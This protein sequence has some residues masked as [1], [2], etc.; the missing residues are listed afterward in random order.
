MIFVT[1][2]INIV[3]INLI[4]L[5]L[6]IIIYEIT[7]MYYINSNEYI[8]EMILHTVQCFKSVKCKQKCLKMKNTRTIQINYSATDYPHPFPNNYYF[9]HYSVCSKDT[10]IFMYIVTECK[11]Y[12]ERMAVRLTWGKK[13]T[14]ATLKFIIGI[15]DNICKKTYNN[16]NRKYKDLLQI[17]IYESFANE[18]LFSLYA[19]KYLNVLCPYSHYFIKLDVD[20]FIDFKSIINLI[21]PFENLSYQ[22]WGAEKQKWKRVNDNQKF[23][24]SSPISVANFYNSLFP[25]NGIDV[26][27]GFITIFSSDLPNILFNFSL[28]YPMLMRIDD[29]YISWLLYKLNIKI[30]R[31]S[32]Y[33]ILPNRCE[34]FKNVTV[35]HRI[36]SIDMI[37]YSLFYRHMQ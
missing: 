35:I 17:N 13:I 7:T 28:S 4:L 27:S 11:Q 21:K 34:I 20:T 10:Y 36:T 9:I 19:L 29:Q 23:K 25:E 6:L 16:E 33:A 2:Y 14:S 15:D 22:F 30:K 32:S 5:L 31:V 18:T 3:K 8:N 26:Y 37:S 12:N 1:T 24:Y